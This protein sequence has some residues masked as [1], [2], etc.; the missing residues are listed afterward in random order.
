MAYGILLLILLQ[1]SIVNGVPCWY[2]PVWVQALQDWNLQSYYYESYGHLFIAG[3]IWTLCVHSCGHII[4]SMLNK[5][6]KG[7]G[8]SKPHSHVG[9]HMCEHIH[10]CL[11]IFFSLANKISEI[12]TPASKC[13]V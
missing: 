12:T 6:N 10:K 2:T 7:E 9:L 11:C 8:V 5:A 4:S 1:S 13:D 3:L